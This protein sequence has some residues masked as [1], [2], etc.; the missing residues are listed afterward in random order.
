MR[1]GPSADNRQ[2]ILIIMGCLFTGG[3]EYRTLLW[4]EWLLEK[5]VEVRMVLLKPK[6]PSYKISDFKIDPERVTM[7]QTNGVFARYKALKQII[8]EFKPAVIHSCQ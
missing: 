6:N 3:S 4:M 5:G 8:H 2:P 7:L 1:S